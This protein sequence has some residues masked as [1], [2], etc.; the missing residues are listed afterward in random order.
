[1]PE[2]SVPAEPDEREALESWLSERAG[3]RVRIT[4]PL[5]G[6]KRSMLELATRN[7]AL[8]YNTRFNQATAAQYDALETLQ[9]VL[10]LPALPRRIEC[11]DIST[12]QGSETVASM[13]VCEDGRMRR[14]E[15]R[16]Y[17]I[18]GLGLGIGTSSGDSGLGI[19]DSAQAL[20]P[21]S[22]FQPPIP[23]PDDS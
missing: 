16:K 10:E 6:E 23:V 3:Q 9:P 13:V 1:P 14:G 4:V 15:Y 2:I 19:G 17:R 20:E 5:R 18:R 8:A 21:M 11:F 22:N 7:A 12:I